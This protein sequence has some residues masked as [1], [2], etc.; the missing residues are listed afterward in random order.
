MR[1]LAIRSV[2]RKKRQFADRKPSVTFHVLNRQF[3]SEASLKKFVTDITY[4]RTGHDFVYLS[5]ILDLHNN[6]VVAWVVS[7][8]NDLDLVLNT[9]KKLIA[10]EAVLHSDQGF[11]YTTKK[12]SNLLEEQRLRGSHS[13][14]GNCYDLKTEK[15][16]IKRPNNEEQARSQIA[17]Y[18][19]FYN[20]ELFQKKLSDLSPV[21][22]RE[23]TAV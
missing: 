17:E 1:E 8:L 12:Y 23:K 3:T 14:R 19:T 6:E 20:H 2:I 11:Q 18:I 7:A 15:F 10:N 9:V 13:R 16:Y 21:K 4:V 5:V 22:Y